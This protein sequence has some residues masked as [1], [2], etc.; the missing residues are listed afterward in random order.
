MAV[1]LGGAAALRKPFELAV[2][3]ATLQRLL[4]VPSN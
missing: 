3:L 1:R 2:L 4:K